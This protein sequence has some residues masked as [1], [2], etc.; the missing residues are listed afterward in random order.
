MNILDWIEYIL[1]YN[2]LF[3]YLMVNRTSIAHRIYSTASFLVER[4]ME[5]AAEGL[6]SD[7]R[8]LLFR[9]V[10]PY[11]P[12]NSKTIADYVLALR[13]EVNPADHYRADIIRLF[14]TF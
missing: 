7:C 4:K 6:A 3:S 1:I 5:S 12:A 13:A 8:N 11:S 9:K 2:V 10:F 14:T